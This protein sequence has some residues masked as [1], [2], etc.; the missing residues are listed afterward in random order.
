[1]IDARESLLAFTEYTFPEFE[2]GEHHT[3]ICEAL[4]RVERGELKRLMIFAPPRHT[5]SELASRRFPAWYLG[6]HPNRQVISSTYSGEFAS[7]FGRDVR[8]IVSSVEYSR[9]FDTRLRADSA[10]VNRWQTTDKGIYV[11]VGVG[12]PI[13]GRGAHLAIIDDPVKNQ[14]DADSETIRDSVWNW[15]LTTLKTRLMPGGAIILMMTRWHEDDLAGRIL[16]EEGEEWEVLKL[17]AITDGKALWPE[18]FPLEE[19]ETHKKHARTWQSLYMQEPT[20]EEGTYFSRDSITRYSLGEQPESLHHYI[21]TDF[22]VTE[23]AEA[24][25][26][27]F[28]HW[29][30]D[31]DG[32]WWLL[33]VYR[34]QSSASKWVEVL[35]RWI[36][37]KKPLKVFGESGVIRRAIEDF[38]KQQ[39][40]LNG[41][42]ASVEWI[43]RTRDK[44]AMAAAFRGLLEQGMVHI[45]LTE[46]GEDVVTELLKFPAGEHDDQ[47]DMCTLLG[48]AVTQGV[49]ATL[50][51]VEETIE[52]DAYGLDEDPGE[53]WMLA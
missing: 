32:H 17:P 48:L 24:D 44:V 1:M 29:G 30:V 35:A 33:D 14:Q 9:L 43:P 7:D 40:R 22:A 4:E 46:W 38:L 13:T 16:K 5:K 25:Y 26:T 3:Q 31:V 42:Y 2:A 19:L 47:V 15:Y 49:A 45:P 39:M 37:T 20:P 12:G 52:K 10:A 53:D 36:K 51:E 23:K 11:S 41:A 18:W 8:D 50:P 21:T 6:K 27:V 28:G 34:D